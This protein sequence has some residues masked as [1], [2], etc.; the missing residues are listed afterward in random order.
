LERDAAQFRLQA[1][2]QPIALDD[3][4]RVL[5][6][7]CPVH[8]AINTG[9][10]FAEVGRDGLFNAAEAPSGR[11]GRHALLIVGYVSNFYIVKNSW[12]EDWGDKGYCY[13]PKKVL[14]ESE[15]EFVAILFKRPKEVDT[16]GTNINA[17]QVLCTNCGRVTKRGNFC[18]NCGAPLPRNCPRC[19]NQ[20]PPGARFCSFCGNKFDT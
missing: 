5:S 8:V 2:V 1:D 3:V 7:G 15:P 18:A 4:K 13:I 6:A 14:E 10:Q 12:G 17:E 20:N 11:H 9:E 16:T 19:G